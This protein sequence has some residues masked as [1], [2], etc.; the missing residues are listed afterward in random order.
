MDNENVYIYTM[1][2]YSAANENES[3]KFTGECMKLVHSI[4][5][6]VTQIQN[7]KCCMFSI[8]RS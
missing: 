3:M 7:A 6:R 4:M 8:C 5:S 2:Y 1:E